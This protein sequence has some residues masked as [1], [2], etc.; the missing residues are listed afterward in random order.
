MAATKGSASLRL[1][2][3]GSAPLP[4]SV[5]A[6]WERPGGVGGGQVLL[7]RYGM[8]ETGLIATTGWENDKRVGVSTLAPTFH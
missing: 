8:T 1:Q 5:K 6:A 3:S 2:V 7:E 4:V